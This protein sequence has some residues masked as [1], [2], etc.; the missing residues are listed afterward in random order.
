MRGAYFFFMENFIFRYGKF[1]HR[2]YFCLQAEANK[3]APYF[4]WTILLVRVICKN[5]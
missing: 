3:Y 2:A 4:V 5:T 1:M